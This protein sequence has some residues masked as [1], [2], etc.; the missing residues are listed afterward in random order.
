MRGTEKVVMAMLGVAVAFL[1]LVSGGVVQLHAEQKPYVTAADGSWIGGAGFHGIGVTDGGVAEG[2][3]TATA[4]LSADPLPSAVEATPMG[5]L[6]RGP[7]HRRKRLGVKRPELGGPAGGVG[8]RMGSRGA[9]SMPA[10]GGPDPR[11]RT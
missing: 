5:S 7:T 4:P 8:N 11:H 10:G 2:D 6:S 1:A 3:V 9:G